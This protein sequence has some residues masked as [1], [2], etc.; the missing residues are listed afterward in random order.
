MPHVNTVNFSESKFALLHT[1]E[2][3]FGGKNSL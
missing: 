1:T 3:I 2:M